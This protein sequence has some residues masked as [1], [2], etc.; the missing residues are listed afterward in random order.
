[1]SRLEDYLERFATAQGS[2]SPRF[3]EHAAFALKNF[4]RFFCQMEF[5]ESKESKNIPWELEERQKS[6]T[7]YLNGPS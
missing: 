7:Y 1:V 5:V 3:N 4:R 2:I 6:V